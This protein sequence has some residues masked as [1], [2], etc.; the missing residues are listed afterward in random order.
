M[1]TDHGWISYGPGDNSHLTEEQREWVEG[2]IRQRE[3]SRG[4][5]LG[6]VEVRVYENACEPQ[7]GFPQVAILGV[8]T[9]PSVISEMVARARTEL[10][11]WR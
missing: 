3:E 7:V 10:E 2:R 1:A 6:V 9:D 11:D 4:A 5:L 8:A